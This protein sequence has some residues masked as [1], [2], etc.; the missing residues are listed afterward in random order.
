MFVVCE[1]VGGGDFLTR[2][3]RRVKCKWVKKNCWE[4]TKKRVVKE[5]GYKIQQ[6]YHIDR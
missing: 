4:E 1:K 5:H 6:S 3:Y 2:I